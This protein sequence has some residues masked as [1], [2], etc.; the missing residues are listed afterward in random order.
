MKIQKTE[1][2]WKQHL[3]DKGAEPLAFAVTRQ[4]STERPFSGKYEAHWEPGRYQCI[5][6]G[7]KLFDHHTKFDAGCGWPSF[8]Q[9][10]DDQ[11]I[12][13]HND[14]S[15]G[16]LRTETLCAQCGAQF[17]AQCRTPRRSETRTRQRPSGAS[18]CR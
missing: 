7:Q 15:L 18:T 6:C 14:R 17:S 4:A 1:A 5:C 12:A 16:M 3:A 9:A 10:A 11:A 13:E 8:Y 2:E